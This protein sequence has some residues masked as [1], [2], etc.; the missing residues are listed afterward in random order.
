MSCPEQDHMGAAKW[1]WRY[2]R[3]TTRL[4]VVYDGSKPLQEFIDD[5]WAGDADGRRSTTGFVFTFNGGPIA[6]GSKRQ[7][8]MA[9]STAEAE[10]AA[11]AKA[12]K[13]AL[14]LRKLLSALCVDGGAVPIGKDSQ[15]CLAL[16][17]NTEAT[18]RT[19]HV[20]VAYHMVRDYVALDE[21]TF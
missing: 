21:V 18:R 4:G 19:R 20:D 5:D 17:N 12:T 16:V 1:V 8:T 13:G 7:S 6:W 11:A 2:L 10:Y 9:T 3:G 14:W 15:A